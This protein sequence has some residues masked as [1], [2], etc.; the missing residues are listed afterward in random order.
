[1]ACIERLKGAD[2]GVY[3][4]RIIRTEGGGGDIFSSRSCDESE[5]DD[6]EEEY[7]EE[8]EDLRWH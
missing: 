8:Y 3:L 1:M 6:D 5:D 4:C 7:E 2:D